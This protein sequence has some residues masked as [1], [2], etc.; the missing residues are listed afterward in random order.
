MSS[1]T[2]NEN[3]GGSATSNENNGGST[4]SNENTGGAEKVDKPLNEYSTPSPSPPLH[5]NTGSPD[6]S[7][8]P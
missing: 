2:S 6:S 5:T 8:T 4:T 1:T 3:N 7:P